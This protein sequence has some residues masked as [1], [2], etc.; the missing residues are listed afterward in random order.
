MKLAS[1]SATI[2]VYA[3]V[4]GTLIFDLIQGLE[5]NGPFIIIQTKT[6]NN[7]AKANNNLKM[8]M[9]QEE[10]QQGKEEKEEEGGGRGRAGGKRLVMVEGKTEVS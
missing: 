10:E 5:G 9:E 7:A 4:L 3:N 6:K 1:G 2:F 8:M